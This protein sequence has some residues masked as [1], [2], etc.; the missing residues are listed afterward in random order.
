[1]KKF[2]SYLPLAFA[3]FLLF[4]CSKENQ[5]KVTS[6]VIREWS[7]GIAARNVLPAP[8]GRRD[9]GTVRLQLL[10]D[11]SLRFELRVNTLSNN[12]VINGVRLKAGDPVTNGATLID[13]SPFSKYFAANSLG[14]DAYGVVTNI[15][16]SLFD[17]LLTINNRL[18]V[19]LTSVQLS[20]GL[21][22]GQLNER[23]QFAAD[24]A[25]SGD[26]EVPPVN[27][28]VKATAWIRMTT[29]FKL[30]SRITVTD[31]E[32]TDPLNRAHIHRGARGT[33]GAVFVNLAQTE[34]EFNSS[35]VTTVDQAIYNSII[36]ESKLYIN[37]H[38]V[39]F[40]TG[41]LRG[42]LKE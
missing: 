20:N 3:S 1:M 31:N 8:L 39:L 29:N 30:Y 16:Q 10:N 38:S 19:E 24:V 28:K 37:A 34:A 36:N 15:R 5:D 21:A 25:L 33:N 40:P 14:G 4:S 41:K 13:F 22:R 7:I 27:T 11:N 18:Y 23:V 9:T 32:V 6:E 2:Y 12:N 35:V 17:S 42:Q 26:Q